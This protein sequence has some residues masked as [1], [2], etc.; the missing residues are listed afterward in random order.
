MRDFTN[1]NKFQ[2]TRC[3]VPYQI[4]LN[5]EVDSVS[6]KTQK[7]NKVN[8]PKYPPWLIPEARVC[9][10]NLSK[11]N[12]SCESIKSCF[13]EHD[14]DHI[15]ET[16][17]F[18]DGSK[19]EEGVGCAVI[20]EKK[21]YLFKLPDYASIFTAELTAIVQALDLVFNS[22]SSSFVIYS[23]SM[24]ALTSLNE[25]NS[26]H[27]LIQK[28]QEWLFRISVR[29]KSVRFCWVPAHV[30]IQGNEDAD[31]NA[32][33]ATVSFDAFI[34]RVPH[35]DLKLPIRAFILDKWQERWSSPHLANNRKYF[36]IRDSISQWSSS[37]NSN[38]HVEV[39][40]TRLRIGH[41]R[42]THKFLLEGS[43]APECAHCDEVQTVEHILVH[44]SRYCEVRRRRLLVGKT[45]KDLL[46]DELDLK[47][48]CFFKGY[49]YIF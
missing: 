18:T 35:S 22:D 3:S 33:L 45:I 23:D 13:L 4:R 11:Q 1:S 42:L 34:T 14:T 28:A 49:K 8:H 46:N 37:N 40:L 48:L 30:G 38:R 7:V 21:P 41:T 24:S 43:S 47:S 32:Q 27:P 10:I 39:I 20:F 16:K 26:F 2:G 15:G 5:K 19:S 31:R 6:L 36:A 9:K 17:I 12:K 44:C 29:L 25:Y